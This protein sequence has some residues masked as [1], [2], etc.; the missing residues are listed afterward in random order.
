MSVSHTFTGFC[1]CYHNDKAYMR[2]VCHAA[3]SG[4]V[5]SH[6]DIMF[7]FLINRIVGHPGDSK[8]DIV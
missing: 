4:A 6:L 3:G 7:S 8:Y 1:G 2:D 5:I